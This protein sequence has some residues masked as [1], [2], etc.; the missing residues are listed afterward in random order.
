MNHAI[1]VRLSLPET[2]IPTLVSDLC[3]QEEV[4]TMYQLD[5]V[6]FSTRECFISAHFA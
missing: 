5:H 6:H 4:H 3:S 1:N 2:N